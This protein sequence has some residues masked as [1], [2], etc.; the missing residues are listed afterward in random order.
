MVKSNKDDFFNKIQPYKEVALAVHRI[1]NDITDEK[2]N[3][4]NFKYTF[5]NE[6]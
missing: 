6:I 1:A 3:K 5:K 2:I 4:K